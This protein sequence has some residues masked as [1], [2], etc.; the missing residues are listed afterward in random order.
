MIEVGSRKVK[1]KDFVVCN[2]KSVSKVNCSFNKTLCGPFFPHS[3]QEEFL[4]Q[5][6]LH[7]LVFQTCICQVYVA[8]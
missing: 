2:S 1:A 3:E 8:R 5:I 4:L 7:M 6:F